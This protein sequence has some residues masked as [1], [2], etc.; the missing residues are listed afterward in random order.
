MGIKTPFPRERSFTRA[1]IKEIKGC[2]HRDGCMTI[3][4]LHRQLV[5][6]EAS[7]HITPV[8]ITLVSGQRTI[9]LSPLIKELCPGVDEDATGPYFQ[10]VFRATDPLNKLYIN[11]IV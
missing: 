10:L 9:R 8:Y 11:K 5:A 2:M 3:P 1:L 7:L 6:R 4:D